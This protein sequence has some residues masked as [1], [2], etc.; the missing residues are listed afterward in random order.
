MALNIHMKHYQNL[1]IHEKVT[2][3]LVAQK[4]SACRFSGTQ[5]HLELYLS[6]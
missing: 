5:E 6:I 3:N 2:D 1:P 4:G